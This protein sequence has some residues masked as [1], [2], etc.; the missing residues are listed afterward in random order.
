MRAPAFTLAVE[1]TDL[2]ISFRDTFAEILS[3]TDHEPNLILDLSAVRYM[4]STCLGKLARLC[5]ARAAS[6]LEKARVVVSSEQL[7]H[8][9]AMVKFEQLFPIY[10][11]LDDA[12]KA[13]S[14]ASF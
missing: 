8:L 6:G 1:E 9:F 10:A 11:T 4:D 3:A 7:R 2:D 5:A 14:A 12:L 13:A